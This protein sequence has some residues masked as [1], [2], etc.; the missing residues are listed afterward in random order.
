MGAVKITI[1]YYVAPARI[2]GLVATL[3]CER[4]S[5]CQVSSSAS[6]PRPRPELGCCSSPRQGENTSGYPAPTLL[7]EQQAWMPPGLF[8]VQQTTHGPTTAGN[9]HWPTV[10]AWGRQ[11]CWVPRNLARTSTGDPSS[12]AA[13]ARMH[14][15]L[16][17]RELCAKLAEPAVTQFCI[18]LVQLSK[19][20]RT[21]SR[22]PKQ[23]PSKSTRIPPTGSECQLKPNYR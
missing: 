11:Q 1:L 10:P 2:T 17:P 14:A 13:L 3:F 20:N 12:A 8:H 23:A 4:Q 15:R 7:R 21:T 22:N 18:L 19:K 9:A 16:E 6:R 5:Q